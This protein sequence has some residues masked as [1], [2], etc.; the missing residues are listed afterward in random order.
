MLDRFPRA[1]ITKRTRRACWECFIRRGYA[2]LSR[3]HHVR[4]HDATLRNTSFIAPPQRHH[5]PFG[6]TE[7]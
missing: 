6:A 7:S 4:S 2:A 5:I 3:R 1:A